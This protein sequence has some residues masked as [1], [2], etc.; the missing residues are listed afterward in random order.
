MEKL[1]IHERYQRACE[2]LKERMACRK[3]GVQEAARKSRRLSASYV[4]D[5]LHSGDRGCDDLLSAM[6]ESHRLSA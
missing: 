1:T 3:I 6:D 2:L 5:C 4:Y